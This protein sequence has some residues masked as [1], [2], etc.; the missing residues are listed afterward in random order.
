[1]K[2]IEIKVKTSNDIPL[3]GLPLAIAEVNLKEF[4]FYTF[5]RVDQNNQKYLLTR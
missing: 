3:K 4:G 5:R 2:T 1:M